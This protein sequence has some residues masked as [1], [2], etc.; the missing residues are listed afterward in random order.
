[1]GKKIKI[2]IVEDDANLRNVY[3]GTFKNAGFEVIEADD[4]IDG[5]DKA[6]TQK[7]DV[8]FTG[9]M[10]PRMDGFSM[11]E[12]LKKNALTSDI[13]ILISSHMGRE[14]DRQKANLLGVRYFIIKGFTAPKEVVEKVNS[15][16]SEGKEYRLEVN[17]FSMDALKLAQDLGLNNNF[18]CLEC[19][20]KMILKMISVN[21]KDKGFE[22][23]L[24]CP[25]CGWQVK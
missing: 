12:S 3:S 13:P 10:M 16:F 25:S 6:S 11:V 15:I 2:L 5:L 18:Q 24:I 8:I 19:N 1:M 20:E 17:N 21:S 22:A 23:H 7:P 9:I 14:E 4:G